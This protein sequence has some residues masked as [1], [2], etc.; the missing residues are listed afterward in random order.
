M[1]ILGTVTDDMAAAV[2]ASKSLFEYKS[3]RN[4]VVHVGIARLGF[5]DEEVA[6]NLNVL[7]NNVKENGPGGK[8][9]MY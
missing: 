6:A 1:W 3:D 2:Q 8:K 4:G 9:C 7:I 5:T